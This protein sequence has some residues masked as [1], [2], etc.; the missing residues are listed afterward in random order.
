MS[1]TL[2]IVASVGI[3]LFIA[4][5]VWVVLGLRKMLNFNKNQQS[6]N[7]SVEEEISNVDKKHEDFAD[8]IHNRIDEVITDSDNRFYEVENEVGKIIDDNKIEKKNLDRRLDK[9]WKFLKK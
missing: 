6:E 5:Q 8:E 4:L 7:K 2:I 3:T 1:I 9:V